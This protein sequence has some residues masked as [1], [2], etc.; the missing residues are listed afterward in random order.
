[1]SKHLLILLF[2]I[3]SSFAQNIN[4]YKYV[5]VPQ[6]FD[7]QKEKNN[8]NLNVLTKWLLEKYGFVVYMDDEVKPMDAAKNMCQKALRTEITEESSTFVRKLTIK[9]LD[10]QNNIVFTTQQGTST[11]KD[12][13]VAYNQALRMAFESFENLGYKY[14]QRSAV[15][16]NTNESHPSVKSTTIIAAIEFNARAITNG[17]V[18]QSSIMP[19]IIM[20][21]STLKDFYIVQIGDFPGLIYKEKSKWKLEY[22][23]NGELQT[24]T[25]T[26][27]F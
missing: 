19:D 12:L 8:F 7:F 2:C 3:S 18:L 23:Q 25:I 10:C 14:D 6:R 22:Y 27:N 9:L 4:Q 20:K 5:E 24:K 21:N 1:M 11:T 15:E 26:I 16:V 13:R 17:F